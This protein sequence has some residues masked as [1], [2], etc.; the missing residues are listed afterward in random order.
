LQ[1]ELDDATAYGIPSF[2]LLGHFSHNNLQRISKAT[3]NAETELVQLITANGGHLRV[4]ENFEQFEA[5]FL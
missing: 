2:D 3:K 4:F 5:A 1:W